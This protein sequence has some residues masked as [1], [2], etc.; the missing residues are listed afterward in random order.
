[1][2][3]RLDSENDYSL[4]T[5]KSVKKRERE[6]EIEKKRKT[7]ENQENF[8]NSET[9]QRILFSFE[10]LTSIFIFLF[11]VESIHLY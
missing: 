7:Q 1:M 4:L 9:F 5:L 6:N 10:F 2:R 11:S 8:E 3:E